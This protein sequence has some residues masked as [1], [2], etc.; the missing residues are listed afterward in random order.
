MLYMLS[1]LNSQH[2]QNGNYCYYYC[3]LVAEQK[4]PRDRCPEASQLL[5]P[6]RGLARAEGRALALQDGWGQGARETCPHGPHPTE[7]AQRESPRAGRLKADCC[8]M[9]GI[10]NKLT[11]RKSRNINHKL[12]KWLQEGKDKGPLWEKQTASP[13]TAY[14]PPS[15]PYSHLQAL[16][17][18]YLRWRS[19]VLRTAPKHR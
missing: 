8:I 15:C 18:R 10:N 13:Y 12:I 17:H 16:Q 3:Y 4:A 5:K 7:P 11:S 14:G 19:L 2:S 1:R 6:E 9:K